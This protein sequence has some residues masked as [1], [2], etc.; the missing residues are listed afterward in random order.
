MRFYKKNAKKKA[1][2]LK[3]NLE[4][5]LVKKIKKLFYILNFKAIIL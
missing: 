3:I 5:T 4:N 1:C 2:F